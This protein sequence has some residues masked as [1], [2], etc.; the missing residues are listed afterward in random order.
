MKT[1]PVIKKEYDNGDFTLYWIPNPQGFGTYTAIYRKDKSLK[2]A[3]L[4]HNNTESEVSKDSSTWNYLCEFGK[5]YEGWA[6]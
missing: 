5:N 3:C 6:S 1:N 4:N 2:S